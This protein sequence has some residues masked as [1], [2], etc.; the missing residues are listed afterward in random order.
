VVELLVMAF[1]AAV[2]SFVLSLQ[3]I[4]EPAEV[5][6]EVSVLELVASLLAALGPAA[7]AVYLLWRDRRLT[8]AGFGPR[9]A[10][11]VAGYG[12]LGW[13]CCFI[14]LVSISLVVNAVILATGG[15]IGE[16]DELDFELTVGTVLAALA[17]SIV[18]G[19]GEEIVFRAYAIARM[20]EA[21]YVRAARWLPLLV[22]TV[23]HLYQGPLALL[24]IGAVGGVFTWLYLWRRSVWPCMVAHF[25]YD[26]T[27]LLVAATAG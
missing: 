1:L 14:A 10:G 6:L 25:L 11:F 21:G 20:E 5:D 13:V 7:M 24:Y 9:P 3:G 26:A 22:F 23:V 4:D 18:A 12:A 19:I 15:E 2:P 17:L 8:S 16:G 27:I